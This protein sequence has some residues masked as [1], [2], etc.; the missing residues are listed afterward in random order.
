MLF[1]NIEI[2][3]SNHFS[4]TFLSINSPTIDPSQRA[5]SPIF[6]SSQDV[7]ELLENN[8]KTA[9]T[10]FSKNCDLPENVP[11][12]V[13]VEKNSVKPTSLESVKYD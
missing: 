13:L 6:R 1:A 8:Q 11:H 4:N 3:I 9:E 12:R 5:S 10:S 2:T 7:L